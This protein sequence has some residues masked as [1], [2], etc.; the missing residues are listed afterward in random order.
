MASLH[1][2]GLPNLAI[3]LCGVLHIAESGP[4]LTSSQFSLSYCS[5]TYTRVRE[6]TMMRLA[7]EESLSLDSLK[8]RRA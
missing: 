5:S 6:G 1:L 7:R 2:T 8:D 4:E 3:G